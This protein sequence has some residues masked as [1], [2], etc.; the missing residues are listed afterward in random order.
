[1]TAPAR[2]LAPPPAT[3]APALLKALH[4]NLC[5]VVQGKEEAL[6]RVVVCLLAGG[7]LLLEDVPGVGK[8]SLAEAVAKSLSLGFARI[9]FTADLMPADVMG[10]QLYQ[11]ERGGFAFRPGPLFQQLVLADELNRAPPRTQSALLEAMAQHQVTVDG[12]THPLPRPFTVLAT[13]NPLDLAGT[14]PLPD[15]QLDRFLILLSLGHPSPEVEARILLTRGLGL[16]LER[17]SPIA[18][19]ESWLAL[20]KQA[21]LTHVDPDVARYAVDL[22]QA[23]RT[24]AEIERGASTRAALALMSA[25]RAEALWHGRDFVTP[26]DVRSVT[27]PVLAHRLVLK[28]TRGLD[29]GRAVAQAVLGEILRKVSVPR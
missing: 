19:P 12:V 29:G 6:Q 18:T 27:V 10:V 26:L 21:A 1:M 14:Y 24:H 4:H 16:P 15:S 17:I 22:A 25:A 9:Q 28:G 11:P 13:Q 8:T 5:Q 7:H 23:T 20:Q 3:D 2:P